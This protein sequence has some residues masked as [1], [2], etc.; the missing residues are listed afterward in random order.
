MFMNYSIVT[1]SQPPLGINL[2]SCFGQQGT[3]VDSFYRTKDGEYFEV[4]K[5]KSV[6]VGDILWCVN[7]ID[8]H[9]RSLEEIRKIL[10]TVS[11]PLK[12]SFHHPSPPPNH[13]DILNN[14]NNRTWIGKYIRDVRRVQEK[15]YIAFVR[16]HEFFT[17][18]DHSPAFPY[19]DT[20]SIDQPNHT[21]QMRGYQ[22]LYSLL[23]LTIPTHS[24]DCWSRDIQRS[25]EDMLRKHYQQ[26]QQEFMTSVIH[27]FS[28]SSYYKQ[29]IG[30]GLFQ[31]KFAYLPLQWIVM[32]SPWH[33]FLYAFLARYKK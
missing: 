22:F 10:L 1:L 30:W 12:L 25:Y 20:S 28:A 24:K 6:Q 7:D 9:N 11:F 19:Q 15:E 33:V 17:L 27:D 2:R 4:E 5:S 29:M 18:Q 32:T 14:L 8:V 21:L 13:E 3:Y 26:L 23:D 16:L 31:G